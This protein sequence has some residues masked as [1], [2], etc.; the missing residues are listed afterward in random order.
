MAEIVS[1]LIPA[2]NAGRWLSKTIR[3]VLAQ[4]WPH[5]EVIVVD[6]GSKDDTLAVAKTWESASVKV[7]TQ[8]NQGACAARNKALELA[9]G[10]YIQWLDADDLLHPDK[11]AVQMRAA[12]E[13]GDP[14][15]LFSG[16]FGTFYH[17]TE[18]A[19]F[20]DTSLCRDLKPLDYL[21]T[22]F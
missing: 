20:E 6:D 5:I 12:R 2:Y 11:I 21:L 4:T 19:V 22:R 10:A 15:L 7:V 1:V 8:R 17:R 9:Q 3:S 16:Q 13:A 18:K 14:R